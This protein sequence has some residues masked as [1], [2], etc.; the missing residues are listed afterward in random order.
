MNQKRIN[1]PLQDRWSYLW[2]VI[3]TLLTLFSTGQWTVPLAAWL[4]TIFVLRFVRSQPVWRGILLAWLTNFVVVSI[5]WWNILGYGAPLP[6]FLVT[7]A[8]ST[9]F[10][11][12]LPFLLDR[13]LVPRLGGFAATLVFP[14]TVTAIE[15]LTIS[16]NPLGSFG[17]Q[18]YTQ[19]NSLV[20]MQLVSVTGMWGITFLLGWFP[21][22]FNY[23]WERSFAWTEI[24]RGVAIF[25]G[26]MLVVLAY[27]NIR[28]AFFQP[29]AGTMRVHGITEVDMRENW[30][31]LRAINA[32]QGWQAMRQQ[33]ADF[34]ER[35]LEASVREARQGG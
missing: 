30:V 15:F 10:I 35:Y 34:Q 3:G 1:Y 31:K 13:L 8:I 27:G 32:E 23:A 2:L 14:L 5:A 7:M 12:A 24:R 28:L 22:V 16:A 4:G 26:V 33:A 11:G 29:E 19:Y 17:G 18:A 21:T 9:L 6:M 25:A 20:L